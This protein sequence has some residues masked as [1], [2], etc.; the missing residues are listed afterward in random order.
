MN[1]CATDGCEAATAGRSKYCARHRAAAREAWKARIQ[2]DKVE[3]EGRGERFRIICEAAHQAGLQAGREVNVAP[4]VVRDG[5]TGQTYNVP[6]GM[7]GFAWIT[8]DG[9]TSF[10]R[11]AAKNGWSKGYPRGRQ[12][13]VSEFGQSYARKDAYARA[14]VETLG[15]HNIRATAGSR[16]D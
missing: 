11:W 4:M 13:W 7:C 1:T 15:R 6:E 16:L 10:G 2:A 5:R 8:V 14:F 12:Y 9:N 3:R